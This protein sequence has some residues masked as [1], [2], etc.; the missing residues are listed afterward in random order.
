MVAENAMTFTGLMD[1]RLNQK[2]V[3]KL[4]ILIIAVTD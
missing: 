2:G 1:N 3:N 4:A